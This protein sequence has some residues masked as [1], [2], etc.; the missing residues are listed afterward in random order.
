MKSILQ[1]EK[2]CYFTGETGPLHKHHIF[3]GSGL[4]KI[5]EENG[6]WVWLTPR[7]HNMSNDGVHFNQ[8]RNLRLKKACQKKYEETHTREEFM[9]LIGRNY[10]EGS[11]T[12]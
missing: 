10:L 2:Q 4:R 3:F 12:E 8:E 1:S 6:F 11:D 7:L 9:A 5:S